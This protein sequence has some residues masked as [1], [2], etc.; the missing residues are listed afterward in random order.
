MDYDQ[1]KE[2]DVEEI[3]KRYMA[4]YND[5]ENGCWQ[6]EKARKRIHQTV[7]MEYSLC[8]IHYE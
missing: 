7:T 8:L 5:H 3:A 2:S 4:Y 6:Y 1:M